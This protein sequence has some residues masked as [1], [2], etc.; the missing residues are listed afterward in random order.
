MR[1]E[2]HQ[3]KQ[4][5]QPT[6]YVINEH[7]EWDILKLSTIFTVDVVPYIL[8][9]K[10]PDPQAGSD[11]CVWRWT[12]HHDFELQSAYSHWAQSDLAAPD[13]IWKRIWGLQIPQRVR[14]FL[15][16]ARRQKLLTNL[17]RYK[18]TL[19]DDP[20][21][22]IC[23]R[24]EES[25]L[26]TLRDCS[27]FRQIWKNVVPQSLLSSF[28]SA[29]VKD[30]LRQNL[31]SNILLCN[32]LPWKFVFA[33]ILWQSWKNR[34]DAV[35][36]ET[37]ATIEQVISRSKATIGGL[38]RDDTGNFLFDFSKFIGCSNSLHAELCIRQ[39]LNRAWFIDLIWTSRSGNLAADRLARNANQ[40][41]FDLCYLLTPPSDLHDILVADVLD[42]GL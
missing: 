19:T 9:I 6:K 17:E 15:W 30:W 28:F 35:F 8:G 16:L 25:I 34:N 12:T 24:D 40:S 18:R 3:V 4:L 42:S 39:L 38:L 2:R 22:P 23:H 11:I 27:F 13:P 21:C 41:S 31:C 20:R 37:T 26:H 10:P 33:L 36:A 14:C 5:D 1:K 32:S 29:S 7:G